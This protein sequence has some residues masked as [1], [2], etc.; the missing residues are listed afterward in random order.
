M[1]GDEILRVTARKDQ[2]GEVEEFICNTCRF[3]KKDVKDWTIEGPAH[4]ANTSVISQNHYETVAEK[5]VVPAKPSLHTLGPIK[6]TTF[7]K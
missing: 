7:K 2:Y 1:K 4:I 5:P 6:E 3:E